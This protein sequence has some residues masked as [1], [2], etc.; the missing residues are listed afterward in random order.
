MEAWVRGSPL[1]SKLLHP[2]GELRTGAEP[3]DGSPV[4]TAP[5]HRCTVPFLQAWRTGETTVVV[6]LGRPSDDSDPSFPPR[7]SIFF[8]TTVS[9]ELKLVLVHVAEGARA[10]TRDQVGLKAEA[11]GEVPVDWAQPT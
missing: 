2:K 7:V 8:I 4:P 5:L 10:P 9:E 3:Q 1:D 11:I 6:H